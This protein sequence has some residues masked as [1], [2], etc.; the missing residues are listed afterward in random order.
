ME[1]TVL[2]VLLPMLTFF[3]LGLLGKRLGPCA[4]GLVG[5]LSMGVTAGQYLGEVGNTGWVSGS[6]LHF[7]VLINNTEIDPLAWLQA[8]VL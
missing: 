8:N 6:C 5:T 2:I 4:S 3:V 1:Y 7:E